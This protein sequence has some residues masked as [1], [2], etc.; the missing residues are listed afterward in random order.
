MKQKTLT[1]ILTISAL[2][3]S[4]HVFS[5]DFEVDGI[6][7]NLKTEDMTAEVTYGDNKYSGDIVIPSV[8][9]YNTKTLNVTRIG[10]EAFEYCKSLNSIIISNNVTEIDEYAFFGC[11]NL[12]SVTL[13]ESVKS[14][15]YGAFKGTKISNLVLPNSLTSIGIEAFER[16]PIT[17]LIIPNSVTYIGQRA[18]SGC[19]NLESV[20]IGSGLISLSDELFEECKSLT[21]LEI[22][23]NVEKIGT[24]TFNNCSSLSNVK[25]GTGV[26][27]IG[28]WAFV[29]CSIDSL[30]F[31]DGETYCACD[32]YEPYAAFND[33]KIK[34]L[35][36]G[37][38][39]SYFVGWKSD[40]MESL[41]IGKTI[42]RW[43]VIGTG[44]YNN[45][46]TSIYCGSNTVIVRSCIAD[47][48]QLEPVFPSKVYSNATLYVPKGT[49][50]LYEQ[51]SGWKQ[52]FVIIEEEQGE[53]VDTKKCAKPT[54]GYSNGK[55]T[56]NCSTEGA[57]CQ[58]TI[59]DTD[60]S[61]YSS[62][63]VQL[64]V[65]YNISVY[66]TKAGYENSDVVTA[67]LCWIDVE[68]KTEG[69]E[70]S[71]AQVRANA[72][73]IQTGD[74]RITINGAN[75]GTVIGVYNTNGI[76]SGTEI[77]RNG[78]AVVSTNLQAGS[79][80]IVKIGEMSVKV[81]VK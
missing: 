80:A 18:F 35:Y 68:P 44:T 38:D 24:R 48:T 72:V 3:N 10:Y 28:T 65:T 81:I 54:I 42:S 19:G 5:F 9:T 77:S 37:R 59:T 51:A 62:N 29:G 41:T 26:T 79:V 52:F 16:V 63:E 27:Y 66:A 36:L 11:N 56:F 12:T 6:Y 61:S 15:G 55:L 69:V 47:P 71:I 14:I 50:S 30:V 49:K 25:I 45:P 17:N 32:R 53:V 34:H 60:I 8:V 39:V 57:T 2:W 70:N 58:S 75:D 64:G 1:L 74:G 43:N 21:N 73:L 40:E 23:N 4:H 20:R 33:V 67:T 22:P 7:Y 13:G 78:S 31:S 76:L 46:G